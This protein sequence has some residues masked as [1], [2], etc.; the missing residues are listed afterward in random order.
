MS[1]ANIH[2][3]INV[4]D[5][6]DPLFLDQIRIVL[7]GSTRFSEEIG[8]QNPNQNAQT[9]FATLRSVVIRPEFALEN[10]RSLD[11]DLNWTSAPKSLPISSKT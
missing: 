9:K 4:L 1:P 2:L 5:P 10:H 6:L 8:E 3:P 7:A 11:P